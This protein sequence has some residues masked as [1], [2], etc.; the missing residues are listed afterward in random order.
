MD[1]TIRP[2]DRVSTIIRALDL[3]GSSI[4]SAVG[5]VDDVAQ[6]MGLTHFR[7]EEGTVN[8]YAI[9]TVLYSVLYLALLYSTLHYSTLPYSTLLLRSRFAEITSTLGLFCFVQFLICSMYNLFIKSHINSHL[10]IYIRTYIH[11]RTYLPT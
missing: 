3:C 4:S 6:C 1:P 9:Y 10:C 8:R 7:T 11:V 2:P 5:C